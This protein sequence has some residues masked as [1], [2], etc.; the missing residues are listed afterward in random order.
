[1]DFYYIKH[2]SNINIASIWVSGGS[3]KDIQNKKGTNQILSSLLTRGCEG[4][5][6]FKLSNYINSYG[7]DLNCETLE[8]GILINLKS[9][10]LYFKDVYPLLNLI[11]EKPTL[12]IEQFKICKQNIIYHIKKSKEN[13]YEVALENWRKLIYK[14]HPYAFDSNGYISTI[15][16]INY[17]DILDEYENFKKRGK[18][19]LS[20]HYCQNMQNIDSLVSNKT[21][22]KNFTYK[23]TKNRLYQRKCMVHYQNTNQLI[24]LIGSKTCSYKNN[25]FLNLK[26]LESYL[27]FGMSSKLFRLFRERKGLTYDVGVFNP[28][29][30][31][32][33]PFMI[34]LSSSPYN[35]LDSFNN[36]L[37]L[38]DQITNEI[39]SQDELE[40][41]K[42]KLNASIS[43]SSQTTEEI[44]NRKVQLIGLDMDPKLDEKFIE[45]ISSINAKEIL[46]TAQKYLINPTLSISGKKNY[47]NQIEKIWRSRS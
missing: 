20:N 12:S 35:C 14:K 30:K 15:N 16:N 40:L 28:L 22:D 19:L 37:K 31:A 38:W 6:N 27:A 34:Y 21:F 29:R 47:C 10:K 11:L 25:D 1:M 13:P 36:L 41:A 43:L 2:K 33:A 18:V 4:Y 45:R 3:D 46:E 8:D 26:I 9:I 5:D 23:K 17:D 32:S 24:I 7:A 39:L 44:I 42:I